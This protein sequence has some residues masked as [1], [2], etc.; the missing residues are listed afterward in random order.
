LN[1]RFAENYFSL[2]ATRADANLADQVVD[3]KKRSAAYP[4]PAVREKDKRPSSP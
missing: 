1:N 2:C 3:I 4:S